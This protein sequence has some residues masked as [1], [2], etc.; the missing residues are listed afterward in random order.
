MLVP[1]MY[2]YRYVTNYTLDHVVLVG[3]SAAGD[4][5]SLSL[6][7]CTVRQQWLKELVE[8]EMHEMQFA[9]RLRRN[10]LAKGVLMLTVVRGQRINRKALAVQIDGPKQLR[11]LTAS[12]PLSLSFSKRCCAVLNSRFDGRLAAK[13]VGN[14]S[15]VARHFSTL[16]GRYVSCS[17]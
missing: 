15:F 4:S 9:R 16:E 2:C 11:H 13:R 8:A 12:A 1:Y 10:Q 6:V 17:L 3:V 5:A 7:R 14:C